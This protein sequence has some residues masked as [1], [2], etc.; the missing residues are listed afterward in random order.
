MYKKKKIS[1][2]RN[3]SECSDS[4]GLGQ[5]SEIWFVTDTPSGSVQAV[6][7]KYFENLSTK[8]PV[9]F[10]LLLSVQFKEAPSGGHPGETGHWVQKGSD[11][12]ECPGFVS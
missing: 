1:L 4:H 6:Q 3:F 5:R 11:N 2:K 8:D 7:A 9:E 12:P 10:H